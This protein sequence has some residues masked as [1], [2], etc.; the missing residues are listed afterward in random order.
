MRHL[1]RRASRLASIQRHTF[2]ISSR[3]FFICSPFVI[4]LSQVD[5][6]FSGRTD[7]VPSG[8]P[9]VRLKG[10]GARLV[11]APA[12]RIILFRARLLSRGAKPAGNPWPPGR[13]PCRIR[14]MAEL[15]P[16]TLAAGEPG[17][18]CMP[19]MASSSC[20]IRAGSI[21]IGRPSAGMP[22]KRPRIPSKSPA[23][24]AGARAMTRRL[25]LPS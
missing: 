3:S 22:G 24:P 17:P 5:Q 9:C 4:N 14:R 15:S 21:S 11:S 2:F 20:F 19:R 10:P 13:I 25:R 1:P 12:G 8:A 23:A 16:G 7:G 6:R 18:G